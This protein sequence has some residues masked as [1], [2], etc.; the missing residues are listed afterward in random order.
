MNRGKLIAACVLVIV[1]LIVIAQN[2]QPVET[3]FLFW[4]LSLPQA[5]LL[6]FT[7]TVGFA[8][9]VLVAFLLARRTRKQP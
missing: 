6:F 4:T 3:Q 8:L 1:L 7:G 9:G 2:V 5:L